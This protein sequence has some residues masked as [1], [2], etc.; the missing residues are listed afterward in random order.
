MEISQELMKRLDAAKSACRD[1]LKIEPT[2]A[3]APLSKWPDVVDDLLFKNAKQ[4]ESDLDIIIIEP[5]KILADACVSRLKQLGRDP[6]EGSTT[7]ELSTKTATGNIYERQSAFVK[8]VNE[9]LS[10][11]EALTG[12]KYP[13]IG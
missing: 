6:K 2:A 13:R 3:V 10:M 8:Y 11:L 12:N 7:A 1:I 4:L 5:Y 9:L